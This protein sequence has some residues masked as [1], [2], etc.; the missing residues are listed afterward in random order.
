MFLN[1]HEAKKRKESQ[2]SGRKMKKRKNRE[3]NSQYLKIC[4]K[5]EA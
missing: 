5:F 1:K 4:Q 3:E 2:N